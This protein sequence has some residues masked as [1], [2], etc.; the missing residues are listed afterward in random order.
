MSARPQIF[1][2]NETPHTIEKLNSVRI[3]T[4]LAIAFGYASTMSIGPESAEL[5]H[6]FGYNPSWYGLQVLFVLSG[7]LGARSLMRH[8]SAWQYLKSRTLRTVPLLALYTFVVVTIIYPLFNASGNSLSEDIVVLTHYY[9]QTVSMIN[10]G[11]PLPGLLDNAL[12]ESLIQG[13]I[14]TL[15]WGA[16][17]HICMAIGWHFKILN[18]KYVLLALALLS[19]LAYM[20]I[21]FYIIQTGNTTLWSIA[22]AIL[23]GYAFLIGAAAY[24]WKD[25]FPNRWAKHILIL[26]GLL[27]TTYIIEQFIFW[28]P[29]IEILMTIFWSY[30][31]L[32]LILTPS[33]I[34]QVLKHWPNL[35]ASIYFLHWPTIQIILFSVPDISVAHLIGSSLLVSVL[36]AMIVHLCLSQFLKHRT[37]KAQINKKIV[38]G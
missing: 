17:I 28:P 13:A 33:K 15:R 19:T 21:N 35:T 8:G 31:A 1:A 24:A 38:T 26:S 11:K 29:L 2:A 10:P 16:I 20:L 9:L 22:V 27:I 34:T 18:S 25:K 23:F 12:Y 7:Y 36:L 14:W 3:L 32:A 37:K 5:L 4:V 30:L 6:H